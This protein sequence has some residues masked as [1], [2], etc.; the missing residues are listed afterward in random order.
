RAA[1]LL[2]LPGSLIGRLL[3]LC[4]YLIAVPFTRGRTLVK[5]AS[6]LGSIVGV[7]R[8]CVGGESAHYKRVSGT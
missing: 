2:R 4:L 7:M 5:A 3:S 6:R 8:A 1:T